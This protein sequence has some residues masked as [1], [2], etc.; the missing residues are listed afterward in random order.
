MLSTNVRAVLLD[1]EGTTTPISFVHDAL[2]PY[3]RQHLK[4]FLEQH[5]DS[6]DVIA[7]LARFRNEHTVDVDAGQEPP[8]LIEEYVYWLID[9]DRKS[10][11]LK[12]LQGKIWEQGYKDGTLKSSVFAD[13]PPALQRW[14]DAGISVNIFSSGSV[15]AQKLLFAHTDEGDLTKLINSYF[16]TRVGKKTDVESYRQIASRLSTAA[17]EVHFIS[18]VIAELDAASGAGMKTSL[19]IRP[20]NAAQDSNSRHQTIRSFDEL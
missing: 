2:F 20:G 17:Q 8:P 13:V 11:A 14:H 10:P 15:L 4:T 5:A 6:S 7:D 18:D 19:C 16:D 1:I 9:R 3:S 12:S